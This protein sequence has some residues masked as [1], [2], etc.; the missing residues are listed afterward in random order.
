MVENTSSSAEVILF[1]RKRIG[2]VDRLGF[3]KDWERRR[4]MVLG[5]VNYEEETLQK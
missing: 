3:M 5:G 2:G 4:S 1:L